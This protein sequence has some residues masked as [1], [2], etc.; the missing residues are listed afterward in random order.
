MYNGGWA[1]LLGVL[2][3]EDSNEC[4][5][6]LAPNKLQCSRV[7]FLTLTSI[8]DPSLTQPLI[9]PLLYGVNEPFLNSDTL[10]PLVSLS[11]QGSL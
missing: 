3:L 8:S 6:L 9:L 5:Q 1:Y 7:T 10:S 11:S 4:L 2:P